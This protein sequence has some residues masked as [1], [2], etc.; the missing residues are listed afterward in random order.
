L[1]H[2]VNNLLHGRNYQQNQRNEMKTIM[3]LLA[4]YD[5]KRGRVRSANQHY[6]AEYGRL[7][8]LAEKESK[9]MYNWGIK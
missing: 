8:E 4:R 1:K 2:G 9:R 3:I 7:Y 6:L 5:F